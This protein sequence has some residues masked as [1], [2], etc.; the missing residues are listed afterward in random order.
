M[1]EVAPY[2]RLTGERVGMRPLLERLGVDTIDE[3]LVTD[4]GEGEV[5]IRSIYAPERS[6]TV[7]ADLVVLVTQRHADDALYHQLAADRKALAAAGVEAL[8]RVGDCLAP[9]MAAAEA[10]FDAHRL[11]REIDGPDP[12]TARPFIRE[13]RVLGWA[14][15]DYEAT[16]A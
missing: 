16:L 5:E 1:L 6:S 15:A 10:I 14:D 4:I 8:Y 13:R 3:H 7:D 11:A 2:M 12:A 9:R